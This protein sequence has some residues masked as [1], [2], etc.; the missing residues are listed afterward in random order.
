MLT[1]MYNA[2]HGCRAIRSNTIN[3]RK[4]STIICGTVKL[5]VS[6]IAFPSGTEALP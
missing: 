3:N 4:E 5:S 2:I 6:G 1:S